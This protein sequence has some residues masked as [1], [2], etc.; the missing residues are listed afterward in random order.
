MSPLQSSSIPDDIPSRILQACESGDLQQLRALLHEYESAQSPLP[1]AEIL[2]DLRNPLHPAIEHGR[3]D[4]VNYLLDH[5]FDL[6][7]S[8]VLSIV[9]HPTIPV[10]D[11]FLNHGWD[12]NA[13]TSSDGPVFRYLVSNLPIMRWFFSH[14]ADPNLTDDRGYTCLATAACELDAPHVQLLLDHGARIECSNALH[15]AANTFAG[16]AGRIEM[17]QYLLSHG[18]DI[19]P[20]VASPG[21]PISLA[22]SG[23]HLRPRY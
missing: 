12:V 4:V 7:S 6:D 8:I 19:N 11:A 9:Y 16:D 5:G 17:M 23:Q 21:P 15:A 10:L 18:A 2:K 1:L 22:G 3:A 13:P 14:G 20:P